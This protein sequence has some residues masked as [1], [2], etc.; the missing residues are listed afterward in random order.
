SI[1]EVVNTWHYGK[2]EGNETAEIIVFYA[3]IVDEAVTIKK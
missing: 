1:V 2:N 3:G